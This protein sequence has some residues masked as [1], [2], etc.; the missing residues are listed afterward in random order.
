MEAR[1]A[2]QS[3]A[4]SGEGLSAGLEGIVG[5]GNVFEGEQPGTNG[6]GDGADS[7]NV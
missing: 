2:E 4:E 6:A 1:P 7:G 5:E 3:G